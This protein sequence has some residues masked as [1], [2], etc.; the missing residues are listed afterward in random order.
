MKTLLV[1]VSLLA[2][3]VV[4]GEDASKLYDIPLKNIDGKGGFLERF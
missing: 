3:G 4:F 2:A 1:I